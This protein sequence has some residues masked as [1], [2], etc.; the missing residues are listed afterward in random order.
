MGAAQHVVSGGHQKSISAPL[1]YWFIYFDVALSRSGISKKYPHRQK[2]SQ[3]LINTQFLPKRITSMNASDILFLLAIA[4][5][6]VSC[7]RNNSPCPSEPFTV[8]WEIRPQYLRHDFPQISSKKS[9]HDCQS[10]GLFDQRRWPAGGGSEQRTGKQLNFLK[11]VH[12]LGKM[13]A[14]CLI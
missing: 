6:P 2:T 5:Q 1:S 8:H 12:F 11:N 7:C 4:R 9:F 3:E 14:F 10:G 13:C